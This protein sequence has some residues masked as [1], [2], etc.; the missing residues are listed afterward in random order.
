MANKL[1]IL[2]SRIKYNQEKS[3]PTVQAENQYDLEE[4]NEALS[5]Q[6]ENKEI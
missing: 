4:I 1:Y 2:E 5:E 6:L 3:L